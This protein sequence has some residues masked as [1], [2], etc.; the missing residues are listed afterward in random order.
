M[1]SNIPQNPN[2][3]YSKD[4]FQN[5]LRGYREMLA[6][7]INEKIMLLNSEKKYINDVLERLGHEDAK[8]LIR[9]VD[10]LY[11]IVMTDIENCK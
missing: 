7:Y 11:N 3:E 6:K 10:K 9:I 5:D 1:Y 4:T 8:N 2:N